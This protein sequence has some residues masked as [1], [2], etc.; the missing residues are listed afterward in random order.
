M[1]KQINCDACIDLY[2][3]K[4]AKS[5]GFKFWGCLQKYLYNHCQPKSLMRILAKEAQRFVSEHDFYYTG[6]GTCHCK[7]PYGTYIWHF[8]VCMKQEQIWNYREFREGHKFGLHPKEPY[9]DANPYQEPSRN[10]SW[11]CGYILG[12]SKKKG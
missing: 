3:K 11:D 12:L 1:K 9:R 10:T 2:C 7:L 6:D 8:A 5:G 4:I